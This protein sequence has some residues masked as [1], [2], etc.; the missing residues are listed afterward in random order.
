MI[1]VR[2]YPVMGLA[3][4]V[5]T[6]HSHSLEGHVLWSGRSAVYSTLPAEFMVLLAEAVGRCAE[7]AQRGDLTELN[8]DCGL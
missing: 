2:M 6:C 3:Q 7:A 1:Q 8:D 4:V 5:V